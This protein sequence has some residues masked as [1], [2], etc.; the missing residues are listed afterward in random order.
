MNIP[1]RLGVIASSGE[2]KTNAV[3]NL[4]KLLSQGEGTFSH[5]HVVNVLEEPRNVERKIKKTNY[6]LLTTM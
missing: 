3:L 6:I 2:G 1:F 5:I 4:L